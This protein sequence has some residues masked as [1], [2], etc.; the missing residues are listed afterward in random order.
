MEKWNIHRN[1]ARTIVRSKHTRNRIIRGVLSAHVQSEYNNS[2]PQQPRR[3]SQ[4]SAVAFRYVFGGKTWK[5]L[6]REGSTAGKPPFSPPFVPPEIKNSIMSATFVAR[7]RARAT[8]AYFTEERY[9]STY[10]PPPPLASYHHAVKSHDAFL[11]HSR[12]SIETG[13]PRNKRTGMACICQPRSSTS[14]SGISRVS[15]EL[16]DV[17]TRI[18]DGF[19]IHPLVIRTTGSRFT[20]FTSSRAIPTP[21]SRSLPRR[22]ARARDRALFPSGTP[23]SFNDFT[24]DSFFF[25]DNLS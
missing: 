18:R 14:V 21:D 4:T 9:I 7:A 13:I 1:L 25:L 24:N 12:A 22:C 5:T 19:L 23:K 17:R 8:R 11:A 20:T 6:T 16:V 3:S 10:S 15:F 2:S